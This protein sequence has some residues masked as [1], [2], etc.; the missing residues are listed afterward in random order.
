M[1]FQQQ[2]S[3]DFNGGL[4]HHGLITAW[5]FFMAFIIMAIVEIMGFKYVLIVF[6]HGLAFH[7]YNGGQ[8][9]EILKGVGPESVGDV[10]HCV[11]LSICFISGLTPCCVN[12]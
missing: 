9:M 2:R 11:G 1:V 10:N 4:K 3:R 8:T 6:N 7:G 12:G 5:L